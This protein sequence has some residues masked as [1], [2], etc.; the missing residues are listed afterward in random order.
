MKLFL[1]DEDGDY[2]TCDVCGAPLGPGDSGIHLCK[3]CQGEQFDE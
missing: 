1:E 3:Y 2:G